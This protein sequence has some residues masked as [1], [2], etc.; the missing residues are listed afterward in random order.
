M[1]KEKHIR[2]LLFDLALVDQEINRLA[3]D[4]T[5][6]GFQ[7]YKEACLFKKFLKDDL[8]LYDDEEIKNAKRPKINEKRLVFIEHE[9]TEFVEERGFLWT[10]LMLHILSNDEIKD[11]AFLM[12]AVELFAKN[13]VRKKK[14]ETEVKWQ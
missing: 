8:H 9:K 2:K 4:R 7:L 3:F 6:A 12:I 1:R 13:L 10:L 11:K 5:E 14:I